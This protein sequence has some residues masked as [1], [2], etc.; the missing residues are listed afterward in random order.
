MGGGAMHID[1][2]PM[3]QLKPSTSVIPSMS[4]T[5]TSLRFPVSVSETVASF[6]QSCSASS[7]SCKS[8]TCTRKLESVIH[9]K[10]HDIRT[11][12]VSPYR[13]VLGPV[14][15]QSEVGSAIASLGN[16][17][18]EVSS[19]GQVLLDC[20]GVKTLQSLGYGIVRDAFSLLQTDSSVKVSLLDLRLVISL[21]SDKAVWDAVLSNEAVRKLQESCYPAEDYRKESCEDESD[22]AASVL[23]WIMDITKAKIIELVDKFMLLMNEVFQPIEKEKPR[24][25][26]NHNVDDKVRSSLLLSIVILLIVVVAR[27]R[28]A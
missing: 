17:M 26:T 21:A 1:L 8:G 25:E 19:S 6:G 28:G 14:P 16:F 15:S 7:C 24:E 10:D 23:R 22:I 11:D 18:S 12:G 9:G 5:S 4:S 27:T 13:V 2:I 20:S 3:I